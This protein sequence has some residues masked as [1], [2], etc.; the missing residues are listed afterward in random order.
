MENGKYTREMLECV[1]L[2]DL[3]D[4]F[5]EE[6]NGTP[7]QMAKQTLI[8]Q[9]LSAQEGEKNFSR[10]N[11]GRKPLTEVNDV[12]ADEDKNCS[13][14]IE[15]CPDGYGFLRTK[16]TTILSK[17]YSLRECLLDNTV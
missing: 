8:E 7:N 10:S 11:R 4:I 13:G 9:I 6:F 14:I 12:E 5:R 17:T 2:K 15:I 1:S 3:R 16:I